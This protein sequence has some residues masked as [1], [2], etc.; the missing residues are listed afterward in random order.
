MKVVY[1]NR[2]EGKTS[3]IIEQCKKLPGSKCVLTTNMQTAFV[4][5]REINE[6]LTHTN[7][8]SVNQLAPN[9]DHLRGKQYD[10]IFIDELTH[11]IYTILSYAYVTGPTK[12]IATIGAENLVD[13][14]DVRS[15]KSCSICAHKAVCQ[16]YNCSISDMCVHYKEETTND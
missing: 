4:L 14:K 8:Y 13:L 9:F 16:F 15:R 10:W 11:F 1:A 7:I 12:V 5:S 3:Y 6:D 2:R